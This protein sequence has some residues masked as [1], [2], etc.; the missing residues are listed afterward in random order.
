MIVQSIKILWVNIAL[1]VQ[2]HRTT[3][4]ARSGSC[5]CNNVLVSIYI[6]TRKWGQNKTSFQNNSS[7]YLVLIKKIIVPVG[8]KSA[9]LPQ[10]GKGPKRVKLL[11]SHSCGTKLPCWGARDAPGQDKQ[12]KSPCSNDVSP[13]FALS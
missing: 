8:N 2:E 9:K 11:A 12:K 5:L 13:F 4:N 6:V 3:I 1:P 7:L 10:K